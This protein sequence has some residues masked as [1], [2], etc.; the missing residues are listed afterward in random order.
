MI[1]IV[2]LLYMAKKDQAVRFFVHQAVKFSILA[3]HQF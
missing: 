1:Q 2:R 3:R